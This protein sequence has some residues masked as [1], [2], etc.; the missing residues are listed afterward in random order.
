MKKYLITLLV[1]FIPATLI[2]Q[3]GFKEGY[4]LLT[5][6][7]TL[8]G[9]I[10]NN[11][12]YENSTACKYR[13]NSNETIRRYSPDEIFG[14]YFSEGKYYVSKEYENRRQF[15]EFLVDGRLSVDLK[16]ER[17]LSN[18]FFIERDTLT[19]FT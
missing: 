2:S 14:Y 11:S 13:K 16:Q 12:G 3:E 7:D 5:Q 18:H 17:D 10:E 19:Y 1:L 6:Q 15:F 9:L 8:Y 4:V